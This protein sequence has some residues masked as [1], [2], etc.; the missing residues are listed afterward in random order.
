MPEVRR[1][2]ASLALAV[3]ALLLVPDARAQAPDTEAQFVQLIDGARSALGLAPLKV[4]PELT[5]IARQHAANMAAAGQIYH[6][7]LDPID[8]QRVGENVGVGKPVELVHEAF[9]KSPTHKRE[10]LGQFSEV[11][12]GVVWANGKLYVDQ[13]FRLPWMVAPAEDATPV[14]TAE[15]TLALAPA[16]GLMVPV[17]AAPVE[18]AIG[19]GALA[20]AVLAVAD[21]A[22]P[23]VAAAASADRA[24]LAPAGTADAKIP[25]AA[26]AAMLIAIVLSGHVR[27]FRDRLM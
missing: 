21:A 22:R 10:I 24:Q 11:G 9:M 17:A 13:L 3:A 19:A 12:I 20:S 26:V 6:Q 8:G 14:P 16:P 27:S 18:T 23:A 15:P 5:A 4:S 7:S 2:A 25:L 1:V